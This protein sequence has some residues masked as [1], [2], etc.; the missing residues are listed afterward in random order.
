MLGPVYAKSYIISTTAARFSKPRNVASSLSNRV[1]MRRQP[2]NLRNSRS[3]SFQS[4][5]VSRSQSHLTFRFA[6][7]GTTG[8]IPRSRTNWR[9]SSP[10]YAQPIARGAFATGSSQLSSRARPS[11]ASWAFPPDRRKI[12]AC[13]SLAETMWIFAYQPPRD[14]PMLCG[15]F[16]FRAPVPSGCTLTLVLSRPK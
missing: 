14:L 1:K 6:F 10:S 9:V 4:L 8:V 13:R 15:P 5:Q 2:L 12:T 7:G 11:G 16:F 3:I